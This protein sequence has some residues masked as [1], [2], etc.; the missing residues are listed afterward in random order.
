[1]FAFADNAETTGVVLLEFIASRLRVL[2]QRHELTQEQMAT[3]LG[4][5]VK[6]YQRIEW[7]AK[8]VRASTIERL[9]RVFGISPLEF[10]AERLPE[11]TVK[12][13]PKKAPHRPKKGP[14]K[15]KP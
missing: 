2:R 12:A 7:S 9:A 15:P 14:L 8:D 4:T 10:L 3:L 6:W 11:T 1:V 13:P 5:D